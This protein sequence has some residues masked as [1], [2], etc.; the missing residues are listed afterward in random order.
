MAASRPLP[1][2]TESELEI[3]SVLW[4]AGSATVRQIQKQMGKRREMGYTTVLKLLQIMH[5]KGLVK[6][7]ESDRTHIYSS[8]EPRERTQQRIVSNLLDRAFE[9]SASSLVMR[10]LSSKQASS[11]ELVEIRALLDEM[12]RKRK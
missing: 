10:A 1:R 7:D 9:G 2:P 5:E 4:K 12:E 6:R 8:A 3:L 11:K